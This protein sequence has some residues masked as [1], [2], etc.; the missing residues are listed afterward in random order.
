MR[1]SRL[2]LIPTNGPYNFDKGKQEMKKSSEI[3]IA[4]AAL[5]VTLACLCLVAGQAIA[6]PTLTIIG[7][8]YPSDMS[9]DGSVVVG[10]TADGLYE[11]FRWTEFTGSVSLG[12]HT[13]YIQGGAGLPDVS[14]DG[15]RV[16]ATI[17]TPDSLH[18]TQGIWI[19][20]SGWQVSMPPVP[21]YARLA[22][23]SYGSAWGLS[24]DGKVLCG[25]WHPDES[26][27]AYNHGNTWTIGDTTSITPL[28]SPIRNC[29]TNGLNFDGSVVVGFAENEFGNWRPTVWEDGGYTILSDNG[30]FPIAKGVSADGNTIW[31]AAFNTATSTQEAAIW[32]RT[33]T[34]WDEQIIGVLPGTFPGYGQSQVYNMA[35]DGPIAVGY[36]QFT[37]GTTTGFV[38]TLNEGMVPAEDYFNSYGIEFP[39]GFEILNLTGISHDGRTYCGYGEDTTVFPPPIEG[40]VVTLDWVSPVPETV[41]NAEFEFQG[42]FPN[43]FNPSTTIVM[44]LGKTQ[45]VA[46]K[47]FDARGQLVREIHQGILPAGRNE[48]VWNGLDDKGMKAASGIYFAR[49]ESE[50]SAQSHRMVLVK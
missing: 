41:R 18:V 17:T 36:N 15:T 24:G 20:G 37:T 45:D 43:P 27:N 6:V 26:F 44:S 3:G 21:S 16:S 42:N 14:F 30:G 4:R 11:T 48:L 33:P 35:E 10:N 32:T 22:D 12:R 47:I 34:G 2:G 7:Q 39:E 13:A 5:T 38:W 40:F 1:V 50:G 25:M 9:A 19:K 28:V 23:N 46:V 31:G 29:R 8:N 49:A